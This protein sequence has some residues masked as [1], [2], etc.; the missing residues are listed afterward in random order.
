ME[1]ERRRRRDDEMY[2]DCR[3][4]TTGGETEKGGDGTGS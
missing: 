1:C 2:L 4:E 3:A